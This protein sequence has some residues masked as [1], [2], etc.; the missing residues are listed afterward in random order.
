M[1]CKWNMARFRAHQSCISAGRE[2][3]MGSGM[4]HWRW[5]P[6]CGGWNILV[7]WGD[8]S[9]PPVQKSFFVKYM[10]KESLM[11]S[12]SSP[13]VLILMIMAQ[14]VVLFSTR[15]SKPSF[16]LNGFFTPP[17]G[18]LIFAIFRARFFFAAFGHSCWILLCLLRYHA[19]RSKTYVYES[20]KLY[21]LFWRKGSDDASFPSWWE[22][23]SSR[24]SSLSWCL[25]HRLEVTWRWGIHPLEMYFVLKIGGC[26]EM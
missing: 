24:L 6:R 17:I 3:G 26:S 23:T 9:T 12:R 22:S 15:R 14:C 13:C 20:Y 19:T 7:V 5:P 8:D 18:K 1:S 16:L 11:W 21:V 2:I 10:S 25:F 4:G